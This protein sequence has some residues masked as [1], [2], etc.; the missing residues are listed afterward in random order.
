MDRAHRIG[1]RRPV[2]VYRLITRDSV[3]ENIMNV[4]KFKSALAKAVVNEDN[5][6][7]Q[8]MDTS[9]IV[10]SFLSMSQSE[11][12]GGSKAKGST[13]RSSL[14]GLLMELDHLWTPLRKLDDL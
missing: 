3:E 9:S 2:T 11:D 12:A 10:D 4:Q 6:G 13:N 5:T 1:Q 14:S 8:S 7:I